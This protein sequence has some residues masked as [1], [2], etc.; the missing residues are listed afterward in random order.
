MNDL[1]EGTFYARVV[2]LLNGQEVEVDSRPS[3]SIA[4]AVRT[5]API[6]VEESVLDRAAISPSPDI[7]TGKLSERREDD[8]FRDFVEG[9][10]LG[11]LEGS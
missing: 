7:S 2:L 9:L 1:D 8:A 5:Q 4:L 11:G 6:Y 10:D 3:D